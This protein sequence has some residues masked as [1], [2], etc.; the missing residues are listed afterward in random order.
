MS[1]GPPQAAAVGA[2]VAA[3]ETGRVEDG[4]AHLVA[5]G[6]DRLAAAHG[7][8]LA[9]GAVVEALAQHVGQRSGPHRG[10]RGGR[11]A[12]LRGAA[13]WRRSGGRRPGHGAR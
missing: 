13:G 6:R 7:V 9:E 10:R 8:P 11:R 12:A 2:G 3:L 5:G 1:G 4:V